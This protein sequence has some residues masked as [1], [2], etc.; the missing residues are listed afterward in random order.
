MLKKI[1]VYLLV[2]AVVCTMIGGMTDVEFFSNAGI[3]GFCGAG[4]VFL[5]LVFNKFFLNDEE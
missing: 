2:V 4:V 5:I 3:F 1:I